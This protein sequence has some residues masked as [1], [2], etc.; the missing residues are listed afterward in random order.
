MYLLFSCRAIRKCNV[1][2]DLSMNAHSTYNISSANLLDFFH[3]VFIRSI[4]C[5][6]VYFFEVNLCLCTSNVISSAKL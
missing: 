3:A 6:Q 5:K 1:Y 4:C 2:D